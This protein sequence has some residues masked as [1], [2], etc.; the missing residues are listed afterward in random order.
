MGRNKQ[1]EEKLENI[2]NNVDVKEVE[3]DWK[4]M[5]VR[6]YADMEN[7]KK[8]FFKEKESAILSTKEKMIR[9][10][11][12]MDSDLGI[13]MKSLSP[14]PDGIELIVK[15]L[16]SFLET[17]GIEEIGTD[18]YDSNLHEVISVVETGEEKIV[19]VVSKGYKLGNTIL[20]YPK[21]ILSK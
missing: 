9:S 18:K 4:D 11:L 13:A 14:I 20:R 17:Q 15:K 6:L 5:Y 21:I 12:D 8:R 19:D 1:T 3:I 16:K 7:L 2:S 10:I